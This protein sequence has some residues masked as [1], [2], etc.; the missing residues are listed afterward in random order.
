MFH[1]PPKFI[2]CRG[3]CSGGSLLSVSSKAQVK[4][5][6]GA[7]VS[8]T[9]YRITDKFYNSLY[10]TYRTEVSFKQHQYMQILYKLSSDSLS[11]H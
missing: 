7:A 11:S 9:L 4:A 10:T 3:N 2:C 6:K 8:I 5:W 1:I